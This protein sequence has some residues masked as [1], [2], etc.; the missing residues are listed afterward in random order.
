MN[1]KFLTVG[2]VFLSGLEPGNDVVDCRP[3]QEDKIKT[4]M[5]RSLVAR[6][7]LIL[8][9][10]CLYL[11]EGISFAEPITITAFSQGPNDNV[12]D[13]NT[14]NKFFQALAERTNV[15]I[16]FTH[17]VWG[18]EQTEFD[19]MISS[20]SYTDLIWSGAR[21]YKGG[22]DAAVDDG[23]FWDLTPYI[24]QY[25]P[26]YMALIESNEEVRRL[27]YSDAGR[28]VSIVSIEYNQAENKQEPQPAFAGIAVA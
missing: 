24:E 8:I 13:N 20:G 28:M 25:M 15:T 17:P 5:L 23:V 18:N 6:L 3:V 9:E 21:Y 4:Q 26:N 2:K 14:D 10:R 11:K 7:Q 16:N 22:E 1:I 19:L 27:A 12:Y